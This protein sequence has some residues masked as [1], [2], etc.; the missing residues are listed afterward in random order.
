MRCNWLCLNIQSLRHK[1]SLWKSIFSFCLFF[2]GVLQRIGHC[3]SSLSLPP[4]PHPLLL[5]CTM[6]VDYLLLQPVSVRRSDE[7]EVV[8][9]RESEQLCSFQDLYQFS[10]F[11]NG[12]GISFD[13]MTW[14]DPGWTIR[15][16]V[17]WGSDLLEGSKAAVSYL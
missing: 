11:R 7:R 17:L 1:F 6:G 4:S 13:Y 3:R 16:R 15:D 8:G 12:T 5:S 2:T 9:Q 10:S 14:H